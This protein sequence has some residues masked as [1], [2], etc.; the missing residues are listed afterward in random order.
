MSIFLLHFVISKAPE[1]IGNPYNP[2]DKILE[3]SVERGRIVSSDGVVLAE[4][5]IDDDGNEY[6]SYPFGSK[7]AYITGYSNKGKT[8]LESYANYY[9]LRSHVNQ[10]EII[11]NGLKAKKSPGDSLISSIDT[12]LQETAAEA[13]SGKRGAALVMEVKTG[14][15]LSMVSLP[16]YDPNTIAEDWEEININEDGEAKLLNRAAQGLYPPGSTFKIETLI[17]FKEAYPEEFDEYSYDCSGI[18]EDEEG[19][20]IH[21]Y[22]DKA[23]GRQNLREAF[24]NSCNGAFA[25]LAAKMEASDWSKIT[26]RLLFNKKLPF[27]LVSEKSSFSLDASANT[28][29]KSQ[30]GIGQGNTL[31]TPLHNLMLVQAIA[32]DGLMMEPC[33]IDSVQTEGGD[34]FKRFKPRKYGRVFSEDEAGLL[35]EWMRA[36]VTDGTAS[37]LKNDRYTVCAKTGS[38]EYDN[39]RKTD[40]WCVAF[41]PFEDPEIAV[42]VLVEDGETGGRTAAPIVREIM[43]HYFIK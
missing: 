4:T 30:T 34:I 27:S 37:A 36:V 41:A 42:C 20:K 1:I 25:D 28:F 15:I 12:G 23:H 29:L 14:R 26:E 11:A 5:L 13:L 6:R 17:A 32:N 43:D 39:G 38:A 10:I 16:A 9:L 35:K 24:I 2:R 21:C 7:Y 8:G 19:N 40:A 22:A 31:M 3:E 33:I 18:Y